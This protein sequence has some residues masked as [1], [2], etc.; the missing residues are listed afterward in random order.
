MRHELDEISISD[1]IGKVGGGFS[2]GALVNHFLQR[3]KDRKRSP[4]R[5]DK[6]LRNLLDGSK[7]VTEKQKAALVVAVTDYGYK[8]EEARG[9]V[10][11]YA[12]LT[13]GGQRSIFS[14]S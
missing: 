4:L 7:A 9:I 12:K 8:K 11:E 10:D 14:V 13:R 1:L 2:I 3:S 5:M 6:G